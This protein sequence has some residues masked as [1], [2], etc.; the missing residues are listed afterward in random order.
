M[1]DFLSAMDEWC[2]ARS[3]RLSEKAAKHV[4]SGRRI[5]DP[6]YRVMLG[7][8]RAYLAMRSFIHG[9]RAHDPQPPEPHNGP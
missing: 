8:H 9:C 2:K 7:G 4:M 3:A 6:E 1:S 5:D